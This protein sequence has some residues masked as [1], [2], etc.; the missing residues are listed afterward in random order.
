MYLYPWGEFQAH[1]FH[2]VHASSDINCLDAV[3]NRTARWACGSRWHRENEQWSKSTSTCL[4]H[5]V[6][7]SVFIN[8]DQLPMETNPVTD[9]PPE[10]TNTNTNIRA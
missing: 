8:A 1:A 6:R 4:N 2:V 5:T 9:Q 10:D 3:Q 7:N